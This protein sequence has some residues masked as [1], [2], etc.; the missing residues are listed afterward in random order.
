[1]IALILGIAVAP[2]W[3]G[4]CPATVA[5]IE[6]LDAQVEAAFSALD[7][8]GLSA[9]AVRLEDALSCLAEPIPSA[10]AAE[11]H[12]AFA[13]AAYIRGDK[14]SAAEALYAARMLEPGYEIPADLLPPTH[15]LR[16]LNAAAPP[17]GT[18]AVPL[19]GSWLVDGMRATSAPADRPA[20]LQRLN[21]AGGVAA[22]LHLISVRAADAEL[23]TMEAQI[24]TVLAGDPA[25][26]GLLTSLSGLEA[27]QMD[28]PT[29]T[30]AL[31]DLANV[32][33][34]TGDSAAAEAG[35]RGVIQ[36]GDACA[37]EYAI[38]A[39]DALPQGR[40][41]KAPTTL[42]PRTARAHLS[43]GVSP[44]LYVG[45]HG[46][47]RD[48]TLGLDRNDTPIG[49]STVD[50]T[51]GG[52]AVGGTLDVRAVATRAVEIGA[53]ATLSGL[54]IYTS[55]RV[56]EDGVAVSSDL[57]H[58]VNTACFEG[59][60]FTNLV[61][62]HPSW[63][64][65]PLLRIGG[66]VRVLP[67]SAGIPGDSVAIQSNVTHTQADIAVDWP[68]F[69]GQVLWGVLA[70]PGL[71]IPVARFTYLDFEQAVILLP[72]QSRTHEYPGVAPWHDPASP[73]DLRASIR[74]SLAL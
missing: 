31:L 65:S 73:V 11:T 38:R 72:D 48:T 43:V 27:T 30:R 33:A 39:R 2:A 42:A 1:M 59:A 9:A 24:R 69:P 35:W 50:A 14:I 34:Q 21:P 25:V 37:P 49:M 51:S 20:V 29:Q 26:P 4:D 55:R 54:G 64:V 40:A 36:L 63:H 56:V 41:G 68:S 47:I 66:I 6:A 13:F 52:V 32:H 19:S 22:T 3:A 67:G 44:A 15:P 62:G 45:G 46:V 58:Q 18:P 16:A 7:A 61:L 5:G 70:G 8:G 57:Q 71:R 17:V 12:R 53:S 28:C 60:V 10:L 74:L 23:T